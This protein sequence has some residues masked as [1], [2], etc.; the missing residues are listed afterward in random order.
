[1]AFE[2]VIDRA[3]HVGGVLDVLDRD[4][5]EQIGH[6]PVAALQRLADRGVIF[7]RAADRLFE[8]RRIGGHALDAVGVDQPLQV[9][10]GDEATGEEVQPDGLS[11]LFQFFDGIHDAFY[12]QAC[13]RRGFPRRS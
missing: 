13:G 8:D 3:Q 11:V 7:V 12:L 2:A 4:R 9:A 5:L 6:G 10:L 1:M